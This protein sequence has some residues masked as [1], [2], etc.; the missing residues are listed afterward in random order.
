MVDDAACRHVRQ[1]VVCLVRGKHKRHSELRAEFHCEADQIQIRGTMRNALLEIIGGGI[2]AGPVLPI[3]Q[4]SLIFSFLSITSTILV[5]P[6]C[7]CWI[8]C[9]DAIE[10]KQQRQAEADEVGQP[11]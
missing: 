4:L 5:C 6:Y 1:L 8:T 2:T 11:L 10:D 7:L 3:E 9:A